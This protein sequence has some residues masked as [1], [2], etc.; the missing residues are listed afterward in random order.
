[1]TDTEKAVLERRIDE[2]CAELHKAQADR[3]MWIVRANVTLKNLTAVR[4]ENERLTETLRGTE[5]ETDRLTH[6]AADL[7]IENAKLRERI[8]HLQPTDSDGNV[9]D[10][11]DTV[12]MLRSEYNGD[13]EWDDVIVELTL[14]KWGGDRWV[15]R[16]SKG[17][18]WACD[19]TKTGYDY[20]AFEDSDDVEPF[21]DATLAEVENAKLRELVRMMWKPFC[22]AQS[23]Y[24]VCLTD[25]QDKAIRDLVRELSIEVGE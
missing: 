7:S 16:G 12:H 5:N 3:D 11:A 17:E 14:T 15:V 1:M 21:D 24:D 22:W 10:I 23:G 19:C 9:L 6:E 2:L 8:E 18:A 13:H 25:E 4:T 20:D